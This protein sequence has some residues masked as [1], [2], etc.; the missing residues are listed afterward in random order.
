M[1]PEST[2]KAKRPKIPLPVERELWARAS[3]RCEFRGCNELIY[4]DGLTQQR[5]N[6]SAISHIVAFSPDGP[7]GDKVR[8]KLLEKD[9]KNLMLT[10]RKH[11]KLMDDKDKVEEYPESLLLEYKKE[12]EDR[13]RLLTEITNEAQTHVLFVNASIDEQSFQINPKAAFQAILPKYSD[14]ENPTEINLSDVA[15]PAKSEEF[16]RVLAEAITAKIRSFLSGF[17]HGR[18]DK[19]ISLFALAPIPLLVH[20]GYSLGDIHEVDLY[21]RHRNGQSWNW[22]ESDEGGQKAA[23]LYEVTEPESIAEDNCEIVIAISISASVSREQIAAVVGDN[24]AIYTIQANE[25]G[26]DF[27]SSKKRLQVFGYEFRRLLELVRKEYG[28]DRAVHLIAAIPAPI[29]IEMGRCIRNYHPPF[30]VYEYEK[31]SQTYL[32]ALVVNE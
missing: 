18:P 25:P 20:L 23:E 5:S 28:R 12:H 29:A 16:F 15:I 11:G 14:S 8:S 27:L 32:R 13:I 31:T 26:V 10:C 17:P 30:V 21:Q 24:A 6:L 19:S 2:E 3:G 7:R 4:K 22:K 9:I 1:S